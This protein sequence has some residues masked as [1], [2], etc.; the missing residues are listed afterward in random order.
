[1]SQINTSNI[2]PPACENNRK[3]T[4]IKRQQ[5]AL[6]K[7]VAGERPYHLAHVVCCKQT[8]SGYELSTLQVRCLVDPVTA[9]CW[10]WR[11]NLLPSHLLTNYSVSL[12]SQNEEE[13]VQI[14][15]VGCLLFLFVIK[16]VFNLWS[17]VRVS[18]KESYW[19]PLCVY[20]AVIH[21]DPLLCR[22]WF[23][24][25]LQVHWICTLCI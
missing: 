4:F 11:R 1:M 14:S 23:T 7:T 22:L 19:A 13:T 18:S 6:Q 3:F 10:S 24:M 20:F 9:V 16:N 5:S 21:L 12:S 25:T 15:C 17:K 8:P 2:L